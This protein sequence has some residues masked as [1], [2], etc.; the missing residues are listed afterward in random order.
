[1]A[2]SRQNQIVFV[3]GN[4]NVIH[5]GHL[6]LLRFARECGSRLI[7]AVESDRI[8]GHSAHVQESLRLE[9]VVSNTFV[10]EA[11][12]FD[13]DVANVIARIRPDIVVKG[14][15]HESRFNSEEAVLSSYGGKLLFSSGETVF[16]SLDLIRREFNEL[17]ASTIA[18]PKEYLARN[19]ITLTRLRELVE[20]FGEL[21]LVVIGD[22]I[23][24]E[25]IT[26]QLLLNN[27]S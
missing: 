24:D 3:S 6:R 15:E 19:G 21:K 8:A 13:E 2:D 27:S 14:K 26:C 1:M 22:L 4:F 10:D 23:V 5:P 11:F 17:T 12:I 9:G 20:G 18:L 25:Y 16:S 7:V